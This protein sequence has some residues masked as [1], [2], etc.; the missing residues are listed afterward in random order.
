VFG[1][2]NA[3]GFVS[4]LVAP[5]VTGFVRD[6]TGSFAWGFYVG[7]VLAFLGSLVILIRKRP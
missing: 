7:G 5:P 4:S 1:L 2:L 3:V 6:V